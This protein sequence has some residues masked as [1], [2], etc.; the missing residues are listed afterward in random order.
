MIYNSQHAIN[1]KYYQ[2]LPKE[3]NRVLITYIE[4]F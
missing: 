3:I 1:G 2:K 4:R